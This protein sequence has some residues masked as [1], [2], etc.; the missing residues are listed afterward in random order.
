MTL[1]LR[2][3][4]NGESAMLALGR[5]AQEDSAR[6]MKAAPMRNG[7]ALPLRG[8]LGMG[9]QG[10]PNDLAFSGAARAHRL[11]QA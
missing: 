2:A 9:V 10:L 8:G 7:R 1:V 4:T 5:Q 3:D 11:G 6:Q